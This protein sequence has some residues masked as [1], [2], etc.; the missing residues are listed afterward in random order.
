MAIYRPGPLVGAISGAVGGAV[1]VNAK[2][3]KVVRHRP[4][5]R[6]P[7]TPTR[8][9]TLGDG[10]AQS[11]QA[12]IA[13]LWQTLTDKQRQTWGVTALQF[14]ETNRLGQTRPLSGFQFFV[15]EN[16]L[17]S[18]AGMGTIDEPPVPAIIST[19]DGVTLTFENGGPYNI[20]FTTH[21]P[22]GQPHALIYGRPV[23]ST[24]TPRFAIQQRLIAAG[25][26][27][28]SPLNVHTFWTNYFQ[29]MPTGARVMIGLRPSNSAGLFG[30]LSVYTTLI[31]P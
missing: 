19:I 31:V 22:S 16:V 27:N 17:R 28:S 30:K 1:F 20:A 3:S 26:M 7:R 15:R 9:Q 29:D 8:T 10:N 4:R 13:Q 12:S 21:E 25:V 18:W 23:Y 24:T 6:P 11:Y 2:G 14:P 5:A